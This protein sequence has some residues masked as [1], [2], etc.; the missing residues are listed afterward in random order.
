MLLVAYHISAPPSRVLLSASVLLVTHF[1][2][3]R[4]KEEQKTQ[5]EKGQ[6]QLH[7]TL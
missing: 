6:D 2:S 7:C 3:A 4:T 5:L 1:P